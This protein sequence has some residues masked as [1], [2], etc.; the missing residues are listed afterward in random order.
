M[1]QINKGYI[2]AVQINSLST[3]LS[4]LQFLVIPE[5]KNSNGSQSSALS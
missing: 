5:M 3:G 1:K 4:A 2:K